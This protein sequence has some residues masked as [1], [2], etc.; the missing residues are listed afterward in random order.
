MAT[1]QKKYILIVED[2]TEFFFKRL[3]LDEDTEIAKYTGKI[4]PKEGELIGEFSNEDLKTVLP[5]ML[6]PQMTEEQKKKIDAEIA[7]EV[8]ADFF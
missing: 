4:Y 8:L 1:E 3:T 6:T 7:V 2:N 5:L